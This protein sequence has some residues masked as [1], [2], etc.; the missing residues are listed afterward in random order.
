MIA[1]LVPAHDEEALLG[2]CLASVREAARAVEATGETVC[3]VVALDRCTDRSREIALAYGA[4]AMDV[5]AGSV[6]AAR[7]AAAE[8]A[9]ALGAR[10]LACTDADSRVPHDWLRGQ[11][12]SG[13]DA[14]CGM[15]AV[16]DWSGYAA[17]TVEAYL[18]AHPQV[19]GHRHVHGANLGVS[20]A[21]YRRCGGFAPLACGEDVALVAAL[22]ACGATIR[23]A[24]AP[25]VI[26]SARRKARAC[27]GFAAYLARLEHE[28][29]DAA[30][31]TVPGLGAR[32]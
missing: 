17:A 16:D 6:G 5:R 32:G 26:T 29:A 1:V 27:G 2:G 14:F 7:R 22:E 24:P 23:W 31:P 12:E 9:L 18:R 21:A 10:W 28:L 13:T 3:T 20:A 11:L 15:V 30:S 8:R 4:E 25:A 19:P